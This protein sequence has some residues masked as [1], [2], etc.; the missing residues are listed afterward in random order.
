M[1]EKQI[2][3]TLLSFAHV[4]MDFKFEWDAFRY[5]LNDKMFAYKGHNKE[6]IPILTLKLSPQENAYYREQYDYIVEG[7]YMNKVH[8]IS[9]LYKQASDELISEL[10]EKAYYYALANLPRKVKEEWGIVL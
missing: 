9:L 10:L 1:E 2:D 7:Y 6:G 5:Q 3:E 4:C 8:W